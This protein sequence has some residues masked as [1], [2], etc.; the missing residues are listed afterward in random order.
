MPQGRTETVHPGAL[1]HATTAH[2]RDV[3]GQQWAGTLG[4]WT[5][6]SRLPRAV[7]A[8]QTPRQWMLRA[9]MSTA[10][11]QAAVPH[12]GGN[13]PLRFWDGHEVQ[14]PVGFAPRS[15]LGR[16]TRL[17]GTSPGIEECEVALVILDKSRKC[18]TRVRRAKVS[19]SAVRAGHACRQR[20]CPCDV[21]RYGWGVDCPAR[22]SDWGLECGAVCSIR[23]V[24]CAACVYA[25][26]GKGA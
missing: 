7:T 17:Q 4:L 14:A 11:A 25:K 21:C 16:A 10:A 22:W 5:L 3:T 26:C 12:T 20:C 13:M 9:G 1:Q 2:A 23:R 19:G 8:Q 24:L 6:G 15:T 18:R